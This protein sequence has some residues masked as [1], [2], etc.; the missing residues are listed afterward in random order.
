MTRHGK[1]NTSSACYSYYERQLDTKK[2]GYGT[3]KQRLHKDSIKDFDAC[4]LSLQY[5]NNPVVTQHGVLFDKEAILQYI[6][7]KKIEA[8]RKI[9][10][11][12]KQLKNEQKEQTELADAQQKDKVNKFLK[13][14]K[15]IVLSYK[16]DD[17]MKKN[18]DQIQG[19]SNTQ[20]ES[21]SKAIN[22]F[23]IP[24]NTPQAKQSKVKKP[25]T[26]IYCP[27]TGNL[28]RAKDL[29]PV[30]FTLVNPDD[31]NLHSKKVQYNLNIFNY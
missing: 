23:W 10:E 20:E 8:M 28:I 13:V 3:Q 4:S 1:N 27:I 30:K 5:C 21:T 18:P 26:N 15:G 29:I 9:K 16:R 14:E 31:K 12:D 22:N 25:D 7:Q 17:E 19:S 6:V 11:Y 2:S 24:S